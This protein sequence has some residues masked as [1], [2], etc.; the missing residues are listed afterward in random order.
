MDNFRASNDGLGI[1][2]ASHSFRGSLLSPSLPFSP[3]RLSSTQPQG[4]RHQELLTVGWLARITFV[5]SVDAFQSTPAPAP[6]PAAVA[7]SIAD[8]ALKETFPP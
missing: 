5:P 6:A 4:S 7:T 3:G 2:T 8:A 1:I